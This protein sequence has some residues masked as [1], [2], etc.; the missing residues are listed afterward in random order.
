LAERADTVVLLDICTAVVPWLL[1]EEDVAL[2]ELTYPKDSG[3]LKTPPP[4]AFVAGRQ[5]VTTLQ[6]P[7]SKV[8][9]PKTDC[10]TVLP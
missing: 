3:P 8:I 2:V 7:Q 9:V 10:A 1:C 5:L 4:P 6:L